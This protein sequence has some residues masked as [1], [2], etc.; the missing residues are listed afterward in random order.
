METFFTA[1]IYE[2]DTAIQEELDGI[3]KQQRGHGAHLEALQNGETFT[4]AVAQPMNGKKR[5]N[6][7]AGKGGSPKRARIVSDDE[8]DLIDDDSSDDNDEESESESGSDSES[9][10]ENVKS[11]TDVEARDQDEEMEEVTEELLKE[12]VKECKEA[13]KA[14]RERSNDARLRKKEAG[15]ALSSLEKAL[16]KVQKEKNAFCSLKRSEVCLTNCC[17]FFQLTMIASF[18]VMY[19]KKTSVLV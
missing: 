15:D 7:W 18:R 10:S 11:D 19:S 6:K 13:I 2:S 4:P 17:P 3:R 1:F 9:N 5:K 8:D 14:A 12:K 16:I